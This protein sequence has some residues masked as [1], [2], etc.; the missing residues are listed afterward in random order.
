MWQNNLLGIINAYKRGKRR[1][2]RSLP[3]ARELKTAKPVAP[4][5][6][7]VLEKGGYH[8]YK[9]TGCYFARFWGEL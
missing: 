5:R 8:C 6:T 3:Q 9:K 4:S 2:V 7:S 1:I